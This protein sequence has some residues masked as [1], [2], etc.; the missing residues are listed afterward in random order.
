MA[1][2][3]SQPV[4]FNADFFMG[5]HQGIDIDRFSVETPVSPGRYR[6]ELVVNEQWSGRKEVNFTVPDGEQ[7]ARACF[8]RS[9]LSLLALDLNKLPVHSRET[10]Q[11]SA[12]VQ[13]LRLET[14]APG[15]TATFDIGEQRLNVS[16]PQALVQRS[17]RGFASPELWQDG[18]SAGL[19][20]YSFNSYTSTDSNAGS[21][22][23]TRN[24]LGLTAGLNIAQ[25]RLRH[26]GSYSQDG[27]SAAQYQAASTYLQREI[28]PWG[29]QLTLG[30]TSTTGELFDIV[31]Y[32]G[33]NIATDERMLPDSKRGFAPVVRGVA[34]GNA[35]V[36]VEQNGVL[37]YETTVAA[38]PFVIDD[39][40]PTGYGGDLQV[41]VMEADGSEQQF[42][43]PFAAVPQLLRPGTDRFSLSAGQIDSF[44]QPTRPA[45][46]QGTWQRGLSNAVTA[47][48]G[49]TL[50]GGYQS[51][52]FG[53]AFNTRWGAWA[54]DMTLASA[55]LGTSTSKGTSSRI[56]YSK[57]FDE[58]GTHFSLAAYRYTTRGY[59]SLN[60]A[61]ATRYINTHSQ[62]GV[63]AGLDRQRNRLQVNVSQNLDGLTGGHL[64]LTGT[65]QSYWNRPGQDVQ[66]QAG[67]SNSWK[68]LSYSINAERN[69]LRTGQVRN[70]VYLSLS[71]PFDLGSHRLRHTSTLTKPSPGQT[72]W[73]NRLSTSFGDD[74]EYSA[75]ISDT[76]TW[77]KGADTQG[78]QSVNAS[79]RASMADFNASLGRSAQ[80]RQAS[81]GANGGIV[82]H[83]GGLTFSRT[84]GETVGLIEAK[85]AAGAK[86]SSSPGTRVDAN[87]YAVITDL[88]PYNLN[89][90]EIDPKGLSLDVELTSTTEHMIPR[91]GSVTRVK[92]PTTTGHAGFIKLSHSEGVELPFGADVVDEQGNLVGVVGQASRAF[93]R[94]TQAAGR[95]SIKAAGGDGQGCVFEYRF[96]EQKDR[97]QPTYIQSTCYPV[98]PS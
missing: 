74:Q 45:F 9:L 2:A 3:P 33:V 97:Q 22:R 14:L 35:R 13:C 78:E 11:D 26:N 54:L 36:R 39:L 60:D 8:D 90:V 73:Q 83:A 84:L 46:A 81:F 34:R 68:D 24:Y 53:A 42:E 27:D 88:R 10:L 37:L 17:A 6:V 87:G 15:A 4:Q 50:S 98:I 7:Q 94:T 25:W 52:L 64:H 89:P 31:R 38:G 95:L 40:Y 18:E 57:N 41:K 65:A 70:Q 29:A 5:G 92:F 58:T 44:N 47:Y 61:V 75:G 77:G 59:Y 16:V 48:T 67:Y 71:L 76:R 66:F 1:V 43:V 30:E 21:E 72:S 91:A 20:N 23:T 28:E 96:P 55:D 51:A 79:Y 32:R 93:V 49:S 82:A 86:L 80:G 12:Q 62:S 19:L 63:L 69:Y 56:T 85:G